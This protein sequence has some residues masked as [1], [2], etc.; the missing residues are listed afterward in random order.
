MN[1]G[2]DSIGLKLL[3]SAY[4]QVAE[5]LD[6]S[7]HEIRL[8]AG[9]ITHIPGLLKHDDLEIVGLAHPPRLA[10]C[11]H[12]RRVASDDDEPFRHHSIGGFSESAL[13]RKRLSSSR[14][15]RILRFRRRMIIP[16]ISSIR[17]AARAATSITMINGADVSQK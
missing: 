17:I 2:I 12:T 13:A 9:R 6:P 3:R 10:G 15:A 5:V 14:S 8:S 11:G 16:I 4:L 1:A 7:A